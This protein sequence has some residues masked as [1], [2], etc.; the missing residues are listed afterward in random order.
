VDVHADLSQIL[1]VA[2]KIEIGTSKLS[3]TLFFRMGGKIFG[4]AKEL[5][6][7]RG[8]FGDIDFHNLLEN[9]L[10]FNYFYFFS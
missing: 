10:S 6:H 5:S 4:E 7:R 3:V 2:H 9:C 8:L 1:G